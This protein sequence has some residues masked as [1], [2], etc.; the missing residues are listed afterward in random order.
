MYVA[1]SELAF[2]SP[3]IVNISWNKR[4]SSSNN[5]AIF[6]RFLIH[7][8]LFQEI[9]PF[10][11]RCKFQNTLHSSLIQILSLLGYLWSNWMELH[12]TRDLISCH[13]G[14]RWLNESDAASLSFMRTFQTLSIVNVYLIW[15]FPPTSYPPIFL[16]GVMHHHWEHVQ[17][18]KHNR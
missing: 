15:A 5:L 7:F 13:L 2:P 3:K 9:F 18:T 6:M 14:F 10:F 12:G 16:K 11:W 1:Y 4:K 8:I 17:R